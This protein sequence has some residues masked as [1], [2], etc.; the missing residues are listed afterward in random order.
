VKLKQHRVLLFTLLALTVLPIGITTLSA[1]ALLQMLHMP[2]TVMA[3]WP[4]ARVIQI[5]AMDRIPLKAAWVESP[6]FAGSCV[7]SLHGAGGWRARSHRFL[8]WLLPAGYS[9]LA[10]DLRAQGASGGDTITYGLLEQHDALAWTSWMR[11]QGCAK[12]Y[13]MGESLGASVLI[14]A[15]GLDPHAFR[16]IVAECPFADLLQAAQERA[17]GLFP[18]PPSMSGP[19]AAMAVGGGSLYVRATQGLNFSDVSPIHSISTLTI[20]VLLIHGLA[21]TR[22]PPAHSRQL[23][24]A[25][26]THAQLWLIPDAKHVGAYTTA[27]Q[28]FRQR[29]LAFFR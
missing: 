3:D 27:P 7:L 12:I 11:S 18:M 23:A 13:G 8:P 16:A 19:L 14:M 10:P 2:R 25:N 15:A 29:V 17:R 4:Q 6:S 26:P 1:S 22:T 28:E 24:A 21:D 5:E 9:V 20:P